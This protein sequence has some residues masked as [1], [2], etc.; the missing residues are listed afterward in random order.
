MTVRNVIV[1]TVIL[2][3]SAT[4]AFA[5]GS[6]EK[7][8]TTSTTLTVW[9]PGNDATERQTFLDLLSTYEKNHPNVKSQLQ[10]IPW[11]DY[12]TKLNAA[13]AGGAAPDVFGL[14]YGQAGPVQTNGNLLA[15]NDYFKNWSGWKDIPKNIL[16]AGT[17]NGT[18]YAIMMPDIKLLWYRTDLFKQAGLDPSHGPRTP[19]PT[20]SPGPARPCASGSRSWPSGAGY[21]RL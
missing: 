20:C 5:N 16:D 14:G 9:I 12:F 21:S 3:V 15:L 13:F 10:L 2:A 19:C 7:A 11:S 4:F 17:V 8:A 18:L 6:S 1:L